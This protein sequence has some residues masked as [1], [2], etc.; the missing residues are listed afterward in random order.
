MNSLQKIL[1]LFAF[2]LLFLNDGNLYAQVLTGRKT[3]AIYIEQ[4]GL[5]FIDVKTLLKNNAKKTVSK[6]YVTVVFR[7]KRYNSFDTSAPTEIEESELEITIFP[8][9]EKQARFRV[10]EPNDLNLVYSYTKVERVV[11]D[12]GSVLNL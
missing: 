9:H 10:F 3:E 12:D 2:F 1:A 5:K 4:N 8:N 6:V 7:D 11:Y